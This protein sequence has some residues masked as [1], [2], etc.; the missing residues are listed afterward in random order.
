VETII[1][2]ED[3]SKTI[4]LNIMQLAHYPVILGMPWLKQHNLRVGYASYTLTFESEY[5]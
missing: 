2:V 3:Y 1:R 5:C 4:Y